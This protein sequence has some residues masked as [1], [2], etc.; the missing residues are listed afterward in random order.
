[1]AFAVMFSMTVSGL[2]LTNLKAENQTSSEATKNYIVVTKND[3]SF[4]AVSEEYEDT[5]SDVTTDYENLEDENIL[6]T[7]MTAEEA[8]DIKDESGVLFVEEDKT[9]YAQTE[10]MEELDETPADVIET[11]V[12]SVTKSGT[13]R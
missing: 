6:I 9:V 11:S 3:S 12:E 4:D 2:S 7:E 10:D 5:I 1:M 13:W 8:E